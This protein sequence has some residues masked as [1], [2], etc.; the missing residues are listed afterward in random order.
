MWFVPTPDPEKPGFWK[1]YIKG[2]VLWVSN[3]SS[4]VHTTIA[5]PELIKFLTEVSEKNTLRSVIITFPD[6]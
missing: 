2:E 3:G 6:I 1:I 5:Q 4:C